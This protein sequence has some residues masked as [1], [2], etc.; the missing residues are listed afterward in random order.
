MS[1]APVPASLAA[2]GAVIH[3]HSLRRVLVAFTGFS[4][5]EWATWIAILVYA[6]GRGGAIETGIAALIQLLPST[7]VAPLAASLGDHARR[8]RALLV[9]YLAQALA[10]GL[11]AAALLLDAPAWIVYPAAAAAATSITLTRPIQGAILPSLSRTPAELTAA[12]VAAGTVETAAILVGP[13]LAG[14]ALAATGPSS[15][16]VG[17]TGLT[18][19]GALLVAGIR[20]VELDSR[21]AEPAAGGRGLVAEALGG[22][23]VLLREERPRV[24]LGLLGSAAVLWGVLD[25]LLVVLALDVLEIGEAGVGY[26][27]AAMGV[28]GLAGAAV[29]VTLI[30]RPRLALPLGV[31]LVLW[32]LPL[33]LLGLVP[34]VA[35]ALGLLA[36]AGMG[37]ILMDVAGRTLLQRV[38]PDRMLSRVFG[39]L[40]G[41]HM[42]SLALGSIVAPALI[43]L[44]GP[45]AALAAAGAGLLVMGAV[46]WA[47]LARVDAVGLARPRE[48]GLLRTIP[49]FAPLSAVALERLA[50]RVVPVHAHAGSVIVRQGERGEHFYVIVA[51]QVAVALDGRPVREEGPGEWFGEIALLRDVPRTATVTATRDTELLALERRDFL[52][53]ITG[54]PA[55]AA[56]ATDLVDARLRGDLPRP[57]EDEPPGSKEEA[58]ARP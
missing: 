48:L 4:V 21:V 27:N 52:E 57:G 49:F 15:V 35:V 8:E 20:P 11:T 29:S 30:G 17:A 12:N 7:I 54:Q 23:R 19:L 3:N 25:V 38:A 58:D 39:V 37:R 36:V 28:G 6:Y 9:A 45:P 40:E 16:F 24:V 14:L 33:A 53:A 56:V 1:R 34:L 55:S 10:M 46:L 41:I 22:F 50:V 5:T 42:G 32:A 18:L 43:A 51:G 26:L 31:G 2:V 47:P 13:L 44:V